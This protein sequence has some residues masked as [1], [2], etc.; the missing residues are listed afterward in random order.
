MIIFSEYMKEFEEKVVLRGIRK[1][2]FTKEEV[3]YARECRLSFTEF[4]DL[5]GLCIELDD[6]CAIDYYGHIK[7]SEGVRKLFDEIIALE[8]GG[9]LKGVSNI[10]FVHFASIKIEEVAELAPELVADFPE[11]KKILLSMR[12]FKK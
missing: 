4:G 3:V 9:Q 7:K 5:V 6:L 12:G 2:Y 11:F 10:P 1:G 8:K